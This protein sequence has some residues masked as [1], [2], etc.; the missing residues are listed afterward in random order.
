MNTTPHVFQGNCS[1]SALSFMGRSFSFDK[2]ADGFG[3]SEG[4]S[5]ACWKIKDYCP[6]TY[7]LLAGSYAN[8][9]GRSASLT[10]P[11]GPAQEKCIRAVLVETDIEPPE[12]DCFE[13]HGTGT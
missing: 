1:T 7:G 9:D 8:H 11:N 6:E 12:I 10:A 5:A 2:S 3:R 4:T 13:C